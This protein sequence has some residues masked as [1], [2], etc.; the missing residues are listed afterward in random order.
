[1]PIQK[2]PYLNR[3]VNRHKKVMWCVRVDRT[4][5]RIWIKAEYGSKEF[6]EAYRLAIA[7]TPLPKVH[8]LREGEAFTVG[9]AI[10]RYMGSR[11]WA[12][13][14][15]ESRKQLSYQFTRIHANVGKL[16]LKRITPAVVMESRDK[17][18][19][20][21]S[22]ANKFVRAVKLLFEFAVANTWVVLNPASGVGKL[23]TSKTG[24]GFVIWR[25]EHL[26]AFERRWP[27]GTMQRLAYEI[28]RC[29]GLRRSDVCRF[30]PQHI[31]EGGYSITPQKTAHT[32]AWLPTETSWRGWLSRWRPP[33]TEARPSSSP[34]T[35]PRSGRPPASATG[36]GRPA[37]RRVCRDRRTASGSRWPRWLPRTGRRPRN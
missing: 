27:V 3:H 8:G 36:S 20:V 31:R 4:Q 35:A 33:R 25:A 22:D 21:P 18:A 16:Q 14:A 7:G 23:K 5:P 15:P 19:G 30:G 24:E 29:T 2:L 12:K 9:W 11:Q 13:L 10:N 6:M 17:R 26:A 34:S 28:V 37:V 32:Q 1:M